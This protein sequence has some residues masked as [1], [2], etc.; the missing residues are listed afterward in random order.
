MKQETGG[1]L[2]AKLMM[3]SGLESA[4]P[5]ITTVPIFPRRGDPGA[6]CESMSTVCEQKYSLCVGGVVKSTLLIAVI[7]GFSL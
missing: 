4:R 3:T 6:G 7:I 5:S 2:S 1:F